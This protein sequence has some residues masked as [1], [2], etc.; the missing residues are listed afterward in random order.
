MAK[1]VLLP[2]VADATFPP[3]ARCDARSAI[4]SARRQAIAREVLAVLLIA[5][6][7]FLFAYWSDSRFPFLDRGASLV[8]LTAINGVVLVQMWLE[9]AVPRWNARRIALTWCRVEQSRF[10]RRERRQTTATR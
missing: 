5:A 6:V 4:R 8:F 2:G 9:R 10:S 1:P 3:A 7:D